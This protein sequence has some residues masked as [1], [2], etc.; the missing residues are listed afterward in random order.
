MVMTISGNTITVHS[1][2]RIDS[3]GT[4]VGVSVGYDEWTQR[5]I[6]AWSDYSSSNNLKTVI[7]YFSGYSLIFGAIENHAEA[8]PE[9]YTHTPNIRW[10]STS[11]KVLCSYVI[12]HGAYYGHAV[13]SGQISGLTVTFNPRVDVTTD[14]SS[15]VA[16]SMIVTPDGDMIFLVQ[17]NNEIYVCVGRVN[18]TS[19]DVGELSQI[20]SLPLTDT[21]L[22]YHAAAKQVYIP[23]AWD[24][25]YIAVGKVVGDVFDFNI[26]ENTAVNYTRDLTITYDSDSEKAITLYTNDSPYGDHSYIINPDLPFFWT[27]KKYQL[28]VTG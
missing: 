20:T 17:Y 6:F 15:S 23:V 11:G 28:E 9:N 18:G 1:D 21:R 10:D 14:F 3:A 19:I 4:P 25:H 2:T 8:Y 27:N 26:I 7:A 24:R 12:R 13:M 22:I 16:N 5:L